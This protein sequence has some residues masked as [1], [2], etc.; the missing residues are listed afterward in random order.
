MEA[1]SREL[2]RG[3]TAYLACLAFVLSFFVTLFS[4]GTGTTAVLR[5]GIVAIATVAL[6]GLLMRPMMSTILDAMARD[7][8]APDSTEEQS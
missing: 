8:V 1:G 2:S 4:G 3:I 6:G 7:Q 5:G